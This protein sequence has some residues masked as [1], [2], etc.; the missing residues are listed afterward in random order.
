MIK[1]ILILLHSI[2]IVSCSVFKNQNS[3]PTATNNQNS[4]THTH[5]EITIEK[6]IFKTVELCD[7]HV[8]KLKNYKISKQ[9]FPADSQGYRVRFLVLHYTAINFKNSVK[10]LTKGSVSSHYLVNDVDDD[11]IELLVSEDRRAYHAGVSTWRGFK[12]VNDNSIGIEIVNQ[13]MKTINGKLVFQPYPDYQIR[14]VAEL[15]KDIIERYKIKPYNVIGHSDVAPDRKYDPGP[16]FPWKRLHEEYG[17]GAWYLEEDKKFFINQLSQSF[18]LENTKFI[19]Q[20]QKDFVEYG[21]DMTITGTFDRYFHA[22]IRA[23]QMH[24]RPE[25]YSGNLDIET[26][27]ILK[28]LL[29]RYNNQGKK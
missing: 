11:T 22:V 7:D 18:S 23:F 26:Y 5:E 24:F 17:I 3:Y 29:K 16:L 9:Y 20:V 27:A 10:T 15:C 4:T 14:K 8:A 13:G 1:K 6:E 19:E 12:S 28:A 2:F 21:Y 25:N